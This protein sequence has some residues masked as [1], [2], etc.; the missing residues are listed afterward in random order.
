MIAIDPQHRKR[1]LARIDERIK[2]L[3]ARR[4]EHQ[5]RIAINPLG[6]EYHDAHL[7]RIDAKLGDWQAIRLIVKEA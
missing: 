4:L 1:L 5:Q 6:R 2:G 7:R 3:E